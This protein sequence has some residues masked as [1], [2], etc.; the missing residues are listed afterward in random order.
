M[1]D[2]GSMLAMI[3]CMWFELPLGLLKSLLNLQSVKKIELAKNYYRVPLVDI[4]LYYNKVCQRVFG[5]ILT[6]GYYFDHYFISNLSYSL[7][8][9]SLSPFPNYSLLYSLL[10]FPTTI[11]FCMTAPSYLFFYVVTYITILCHHALQR[12]KLKMFE[13]LAFLFRNIWRGTWRVDFFSWN[14][15]II[16]QFL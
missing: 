9:W 8:I 11:H 14:F 12:C 10:S 13:L 4:K 15:F 7:S 6:I 2:S 3:P 16:I 1:C 5:L